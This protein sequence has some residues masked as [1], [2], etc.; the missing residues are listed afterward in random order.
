MTSAESLV[1]K[2]SSIT[3][4]VFGSDDN[5]TDVITWLHTNLFNLAVGA[6]APF[7]LS[8][9]H[10][11]A[12]SCA[13]GVSEAVLAAPFISAVLSRVDEFEFSVTCESTPSLGTV[14]KGLDELTD[15]LI[16]R[17][18]MG[19]FKPATAALCETL[20][21]TAVTNPPGVDK[22]LSPNS[23]ME[24]SETLGLTPTEGTTGDQGNDFPKPG[25]DEGSAGAGGT[26]VDGGTGSDNDGSKQNPIPVLEEKK[27]DEGKGYLPIPPAP[28]EDEETNQTKPCFEEGTRVRMSFGAGS[29]MAW[30]GGL[31]G[32]VTS[33]G[34]R[35]IGF[36]DGDLQFF[37]E[38][39]LS[40]RMAAG[41]ISATGDDMPGMVESTSGVPKAAA[42]STVHEGGKAAAKVVGVCIGEV[43]GH[44][45][46]NEI[47][48]EQHHVCIAAFGQPSART[49]R[50]RNS[51]SALQQPTLRELTGFHTFRRGDCVQYAAVQQDDITYYA[52]IFAVVL[53]AKTE[54]EQGRKLLVLYD[55]EAHFFF[56]GAW[57][58]WQRV[59][60]TNSPADI[61][62]NSTAKT[63]TATEYV[64]MLE[65]RSIQT[66]C[67]DLQASLHKFNHFDLFKHGTV[68][69][70]AQC[71]CGRTGRRKRRRRS[72]RWQRLRR[73]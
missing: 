5:G 70:A 31:V 53:P 61:E 15:K 13:E 21:D 60:I 22:P 45:L 63:L 19:Y 39:E 26:N 11:L 51:N 54:S 57:T 65:V 47:M 37:D 16:N 52:V 10:G 66:N 7:E 59:H 3:A 50:R 8:V 44:R 23:S 14:Y 18:A 73:L 62:E 1:S 32:G 49:R 12:D 4:S 34:A 46:A 42:F 35:I 30:F 2:E 38:Q 36:D 48:Y 67:Y 17:F 41:I 72:A 33:T 69:I 9:K 68:L 56:L 6:K 71:M 64:K 27:D 29:N 43:I 58:E 40:S 55:K 28:L 24:L 25:V 20:T